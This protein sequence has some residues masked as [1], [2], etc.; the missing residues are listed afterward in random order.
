MA[1]SVMKKEN[2]QND[3]PVIVSFVIINYNN[4]LA[5][6]QLVE[7]PLYVDYQL[8][9]EKELVQYLI[10]V[11][12]LIHNAGYKTFSYFGQV[13]HP[14]D[15]IYAA[16]V[17][18]RLHDYV[19]VAVIDYNFYDGYGLVLD[20]ALPAMMASIPAISSLLALIKLSPSGLPWAVHRNAFLH[21]ICPS[22]MRGRHR[23]RV[24]A[25]L[26]CRCS[27]SCLPVS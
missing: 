20:C 27:T 10:P 24:P 17:A 6:G 2:N 14:H 26:P 11:Y 12:D 23:Q 4:S 9:R 15:G 18:T 16:G 5:N 21:G 7:A 19:D 1:T 8:F 22:R 13:L 25:R 3:H